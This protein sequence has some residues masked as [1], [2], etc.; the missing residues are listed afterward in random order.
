MCVCVRACVCVT[1]DYAVSA[2]FFGDGTCNV[3]QF[4]EVS[5]THVYTHTHTQMQSPW[6]R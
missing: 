6:H 1:Q 4:Y 5:V 3:G 2:S